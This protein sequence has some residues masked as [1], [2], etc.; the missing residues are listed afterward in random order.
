MSQTVTRPWADPRVGDLMITAKG[1]RLT[2]VSIGAGRVAYE[3]RD[4]NVKA[5]ESHVWCS[6]GGQSKR[7]ERRASS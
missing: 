7:Y 5:V 1:R 2:V 3:D 4:A 6:W